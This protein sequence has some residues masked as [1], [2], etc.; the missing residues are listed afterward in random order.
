MPILN[1]KEAKIYYE[2]IGNGPPI[3]LLAPGGMRSSGPFWDKV[4]WNPIHLLAEDYTLI[5]MDQRNAG[6]SSSDVEG[7]E[8][9]H[10]FTNDQVELVDEL[11]LDRF[12]IMGMCI[13]GPYAMGLI[14]ALP[15]RICS[16][17]IF[18]TIGLK[19]N[20]EDFFNMFDD[21]VEELKPRFPNV[22]ESDWLS[23]RSN[24]FDSDFLFNVSEDFAK[25]CQ[26]PLLVLMG[27]DLYHPEE[28]SRKLAELAPNAQLVEQWKEAPHSDFAKTEIK[29]FLAAHSIGPDL[30]TQN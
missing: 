14:K 17:V 1:G 5:V 19:D 18:Q 16:A 23:F 27:K 8:G 6:K 10:T 28:S 24:M 2:I 4:S 20:R 9:W 11:G 29:Q 30:G 12:H 25:S 3:L 13:G 7:D 22:R 15:D 21:W 26:T